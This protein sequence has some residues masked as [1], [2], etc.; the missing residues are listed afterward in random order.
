[1]YSLRLQATNHR[2]TPFCPFACAPIPFELGKLLPPTPDPD[3]AS[4]PETEVGLV[5]VA[6]GVPGADEGADPDV[7]ADMDEG[8]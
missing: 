5:A 4:E 8:G 3:L 2:L 1:M 6:L 7:D